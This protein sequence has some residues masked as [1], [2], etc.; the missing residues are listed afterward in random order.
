[1]KYAR[2]LILFVGACSGS[3]PELSPDDVGDMSS[4]VPASDAGSADAEPLDAGPEDVGDQML[5]EIVQLEMDSDMACVLWSDGEVECWGKNVEE[6]QAAPSSDLRFR[7]IEVEGTGLF[8]GVT[9]ENNAHCVQPVLESDPSWIEL[10]VARETS[11]DVREIHLGEVGRTCILG[12]DNEIECNNGDEP[13]VFTSVPAGPFDSLSVHFEIACALRPDGTATCF[14]DPDPVDSEMIGSPEPA[15]GPFLEIHAGRL[16]HCG[17]LETGA[18][19]CWGVDDPTF[20]TP[21][22]DGVF[23]TMALGGTTGCAIRAED[24]RVECWRLGAEPPDVEFKLVAAENQLGC[25]V[26]LDDKV[27]CWTRD[28]DGFFNE[29]QII[30]VP[31]HLAYEAP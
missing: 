3:Q 22:P 25:G 5:R 12:T 19:R 7:R 15:Q 26:T 30:P 6:F 17:L 1:M 4:D 11:G 10:D 18:I 8:C 9:T 16:F 2:L 23:T 27:A 29:G 24:S 21:P 13:P 20:V 31:E 14:G 28:P